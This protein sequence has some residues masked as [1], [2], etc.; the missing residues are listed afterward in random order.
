M[1]GNA[2]SPEVEQT[3]PLPLSPPNTGKRL[4]AKVAT[5]TDSVSANLNDVVLR[6]EQELEGVEWNGDN[7]VDILPETAEDMGPGES[8]RGRERER[9]RERERLLVQRL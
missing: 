7:E 8:K 1:E 9:E 6:M 5:T 3:P 2:T 4:P